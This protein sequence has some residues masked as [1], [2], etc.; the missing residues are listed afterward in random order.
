MTLLILLEGAKEVAPIDWYQ[1]TI[2]GAGGAVSYVHC[3]MPGPPLQTHQDTA[4]VEGQID[5]G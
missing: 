2:S 1:D 4:R 5:A 3:G